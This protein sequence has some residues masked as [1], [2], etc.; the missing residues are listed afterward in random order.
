[1]VHGSEIYPHRPDLSGLL[2]Y[3]CKPCEAWVGTHMKTGEPLGTLAN[4]QTRNARMR[5][6]QWFDPIWKKG[7]A[8]RRDAYIWLAGQLGIP[9]DDTHIGSFD[10]ETCD[11][12]VNAVKAWR[13][14]NGT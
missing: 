9:F 3:A 1:M 6:H 8:K 5:A 10:I 13:E 14:S 12:V 7:H 4:K 2:F 11:R